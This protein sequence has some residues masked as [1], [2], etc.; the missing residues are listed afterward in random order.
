MFAKMFSAI[1]S[2]MSWC[3]FKPSCDA[4]SLTMIGGLMWMIFCSV[5]GSVV[6]STAPVGS[7]STAGAS[8][9]GAGGGGAVGPG[10]GWFR[11]REMG[12]RTAARFV[13]PSVSVRFGF[14]FFSSISET[15][16]TLR[17][18]VAFGFGSS[19]G[20]A[21]G[22]VGAATFGFA[23][24]SAGAGLETFAGAWAFALLV[25]LA[26]SFAFGDDEA[27]A[28]TGLR[29]VVALR[30]A[31]FVVFVAIKKNYKCGHG[32]FT[33]NRPLLCRGCLLMNSFVDLLRLGFVHRKNLHQ[34]F[35]RRI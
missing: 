7:A 15:L 2:A 12:G 26:A 20:F 35:D 8:G 24:V 28:L 4:N 16:S 22:L 21:G 30:A 31:G 25:S 6:G 14:G 9:A 17:G 1:S 34:I 18:A 27:A 32:R 10:G 29:A 3:G 19:T 23:G 33:N 11:R 13:A 5:S